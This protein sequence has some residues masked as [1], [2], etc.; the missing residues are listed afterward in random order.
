MTDAIVCK[1]ISE[2]EIPEVIREVVKNTPDLP[3]FAEKDPELL[4]EKW[5]EYMKLG[6]A[7]SFGAYKNDRPVGLMLGIIMPDLFSKTSQALECA[8]Q[9]IPEYRRTGVG[10]KLLKMFEQAAKD[11]GCARVVFGASTEWEHES[12]VRLYRRLG[13]EPIST[14]VAK[15]L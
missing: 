13:Y 7:R 4:I 11:A 9:V 6:F 2:S 1:T 5:T 3:Y 15:N 14:A 12:M 8:W 10:V